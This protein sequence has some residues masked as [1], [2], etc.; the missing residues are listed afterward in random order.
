MTTIPRRPPG[1]NTHDPPAAKSS[2]SWKDGTSARLRRTRSKAPFVRAVDG[3]SKDG[4]EVRRR[5]ARERAI[6][7]G[8]ASLGDTDLVTLLLGTGMAG[9]S[10]AV[11]ASE[12]LD[13]FG[14]LEGIANLG[15]AVLAGQSGLGLAK[16]MR[17]VASLELGRRALERSARPRQALPTPAAVAGWFASRLGPLAHEEMWVISPDGRNGMRDETRGR[18]RPTW[19]RGHRRRHPPVGAR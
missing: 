17:V 6:E 8:I 11:V 3:S 19:R 13:R 10:V 16:T 5:G 9:R 12:L 4:E 2:S 14:G 15:P 7:E 1:A 18:A